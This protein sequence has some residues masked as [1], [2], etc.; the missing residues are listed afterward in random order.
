M[1]P[2]LDSNIRKALH[3]LESLGFRTE[4][5]SFRLG[6]GNGPDNVGVTLHKI[7]QGIFALVDA[8]R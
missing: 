5:Q 7:A 3:D 2:T 1:N 4:R 8:G 6:H